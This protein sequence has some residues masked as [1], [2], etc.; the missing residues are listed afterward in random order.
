MTGPTASMTQAAP[1]RAR[2]RSRAAFETRMLLANGEQP[3]VAHPSRPRADRPDGL[4]RA[5]PRGTA[6][7][8]PRAGWRARARRRID[9]LHRPGHRN[10]VRPA[11]RG[12]APARVDA[13]RARRP[14]RRQGPRG[15]L[16]ARRPGARRS[17][18]SGSRSAPDRSRA[19]C[20]R[21][22]SPCCW[23]V[24]PSSA[25][26]L[27]LAGTLR[28]EAVLAVANLVWVLLLGLGLLAADGRAARHPRRRRGRPAVG[29]ARRRDA[30]GPRRRWLAVGAVGRA[31][32]VGRRRPA[33]L[34]R[35][36]LPLVGLR[37][38][39]PS[40]PA[41]RVVALTP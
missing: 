6:A 26:A 22:P 29:G 33:L 15:A 5:R 10:R 11:R 34:G 7:R 16:R 8:R 14:A 9:R 25:L 17:V 13:P 32:R 12:A 21:L 38:P 40:K 30:R 20:S 39:T 4:L 31:R 41:G 23:E 37:Q 28:A 18:P 24:P 3:R 19:G 36:R 27:L 35:P 1:A 2:V